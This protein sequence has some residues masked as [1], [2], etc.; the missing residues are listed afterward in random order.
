MQGTSKAPGARGLIKLGE[1]DEAGNWPMV[2]TV[3]G[4]RHLPGSGYYELFLMHDGRPLKCGIFNVKAGETT[5]KFT[6]PLHV[7]GQRRLG[8][9][10]LAQGRAEPG[11]ALLTTW[12]YGAVR[13][14]ATNAAWVIGI[15]RSRNVSAAAANCWIS[16]CAASWFRKEQKCMRL[17]GLQLQ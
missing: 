17:R 8:R 16:Y 7:R 12:S 5:M 13:S 1:Q 10:A 15:W 6:R 4:L 2:V 3:K 11:P 14:F 9:D